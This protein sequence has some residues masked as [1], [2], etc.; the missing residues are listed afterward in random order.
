MTGTECLQPGEQLAHRSRLQIHQHA[1][2]DD[3]GARARVLQRDR[4]RAI[5]EIQRHQLQVRSRRNTTQHGAFVGLGRRMIK[6]DEFEVGIFKGQTQGQRIEAGAEHDQALTAGRD[7]PAHLQLNPA[8][9]QCVMLQDAGL[10]QSGQTAPA[11]TQ[12]AE[13]KRSQQ[14]ASGASPGEK[15]ATPFSGANGDQRGISRRSGQQYACSGNQP[16]RCTGRIGLHD[17]PATFAAAVV[18]VSAAAKRS[19]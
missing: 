11:G 5:T 14:A 9:A 2:R 12:Y 17:A 15:C 19:R 4:Q 6:L 18:V 16:R 1:L 13:V 3:G 8:F 7:L 10:D